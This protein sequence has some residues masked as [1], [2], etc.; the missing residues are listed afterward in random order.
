MQHWRF[1]WTKADRLR[2][3]KFVG[4]REDKEPKDV[5]KDYVES[6]SALLRHLPHHLRN[7]A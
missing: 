1:G 3:S 7:E 2:H 5:V 6:S 4:L